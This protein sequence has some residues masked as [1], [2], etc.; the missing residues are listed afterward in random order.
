MAFNIKT[1]DAFSSEA[2]RCEL[3]ILPILREAYKKVSTQFSLWIQKSIHYDN[4][5]NGTPDYL[6]S[7]R[8]AR[9]KTVLEYPLLM[10]A[11]A[12]KHDFEQSR[13]Q[14]LAELVAAQKLNQNETGSVYGIVTDG[15]Y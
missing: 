3:I 9:G 6:I 8:S 2:A 1:L 13:A 10:V 7:K 4:K 15:K 11:E 5:L 12:K 14:C